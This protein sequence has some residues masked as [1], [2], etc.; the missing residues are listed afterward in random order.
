[1]SS[2]EE[3]INL[4]N[5]ALPHCLTAHYD[6]SVNKAIAQTY[7]NEVS[8]LGIAWSGTSP[9]VDFN[10]YDPGPGTFNLVYFPVSLV[11]DPKPYYGAAFL[12]A[13]PT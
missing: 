12:V 9:I 5:I 11:L 6:L 2:N 13:R 7:L 3:P 1:M 10:L 8:L 4:M